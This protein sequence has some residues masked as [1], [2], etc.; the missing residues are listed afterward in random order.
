MISQSENG[1]RVDTYLAIASVRAVREFSDQP[2][3]DADLE[4]ILQAGRATGSSQNRQPWRFVVVTSRHL[5]DQL[6][7][8]VYAPENIEGCA[9]AVAVVVRSPNQ[10]FD[11]GRATQDMI[12]AAW[13]SGIGSCPN[14]VRERERVY[15]LLRVPE[16]RHIAVIL[17]FGYPREPQSLEGKTVEG[18]LSRIKRKP[19][20]EIVTRL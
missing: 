1:E 9:A 20:E 4:R 15:Q 3:A 6:A 19:L 11:A 10:A 7:G 14:G 17:S 12:L 5:L 16:D 8:A 13:A 18:L 2:I